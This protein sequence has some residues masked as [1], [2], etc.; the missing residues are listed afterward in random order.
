MP[1]RLLLS[2][3]WLLVA[4]S[5]ACCQEYL[6][7][8]TAAPADASPLLNPLPLTPPSDPGT[9][10]P[11]AAAEY[12]AAPSVAAPLA[13]AQ[14]P[15]PQV[16]VQA[17]AK[18]WEGSIELGVNGSEGNSQTYNFRG[19]AKLKRKT[20]INVLSADFD[21]RQDSA[22]NVET[23]NKAYLDWRYEHFLGKSPWTC[24]VHGTVEH[25][26]FQAYD[27]R[28]ALDSGVGYRFL[29]SDTT[30]LTGRLGAGT[31]REFDGPDDDWVPEGVFGLE[32]EHKINHRH[33]FSISAEY[34][35]DVTQFEDY[36]MVNKASWEILLDEAM[37]LSAKLGV[38]DRYDSTPEGRKPND[39]D[40]SVV[41]MWSF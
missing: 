28:V 11:R 30:L 40:Y 22:D 24:F 23:A 27:L 13:A 21:F 20:E 37:H 26:A 4:A 41:L 33:K 29:K 16:E 19:G 17:P 5:T 25:D 39:L 7:P 34:R 32:F 31:S 9:S 3:T 36:R 2:V 1:Y 15:T 35:P 8:G 6:A 18:L 38:T 10:A 12:F 14:V